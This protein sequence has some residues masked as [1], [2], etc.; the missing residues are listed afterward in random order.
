MKKLICILLTVVAL[1]VMAVPVM[2][3]PVGTEVTLS[4]TVYTNSMQLENKLFATTWAVIPDA[5]YATLG[6][7]ASGNTFDWGLHVQ[8]VA[9]GSY[10]L[11][12]YADKENRFTNWGG[13]NPGFVITTITVTGGIANASGSTELNMDLP[14][15]PDWNATLAG[16][17]DSG[18]PATGAKIWLVPASFLTGGTSL[19]LNAWAPSNNWL[20]ETG[21]INY[22]DLQME[23]P[24]KSISVNPSAINFGILAQGQTA[25]GGDII[26]TNIGT[27]PCT[28]TASVPVTN[29][30][31]Y[32]LLD[33][34]A[35]SAYSSG[36]LAV[37]G[38]DTVAVTLPVPA[39]CPVGA[40]TNTLTFTAN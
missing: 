39:S 18:Y 19:P 1:L 4:G 7:N 21:L 31:Q 5:T 8:G 11:I 9:D 6:Y 17:A 20:F 29:V 16:A 33:G 34:G 38:T 23:S 10:A 37:A 30:F 14:C 27:V 3:V 2:A 15:P 32:L 25:N 36:A 28:V 24:I 12:Y 40:E 35:V 26:I 13:N 22:N